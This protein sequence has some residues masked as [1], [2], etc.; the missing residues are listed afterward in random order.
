MVNHHGDLNIFNNAYK[1]KII[2]K[3]IV[4]NRHKMGTPHFIF[5]PTNRNDFG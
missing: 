1:S 5:N 4:A 3:L 2:R